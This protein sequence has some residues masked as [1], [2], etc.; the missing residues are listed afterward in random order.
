MDRHTFRLGVYGGSFNP[1]HI[2]HLRLVLEAQE[3]LGL[4]RVDLVPSARPPHKSEKGILPFAVRREL[5]HLAVADL[6]GVFVND[7][8]E[9]R[10]GP[11]YTID[12]L[13]QYQRENPGKQIYYLMGTWDLLSLPTWHRGLEL[14]TVANLVVIERGNKGRADVEAFLDTHRQQFALLEQKNDDCWSLSP[15]RTLHYVRM[16]RL[17]ISATL[18][19]ERF[20]SGKSITFFVPEAVEHGLERM[21]GMISE[22]W[23]VP[24]RHEE[25]DTCLSI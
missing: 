10:P 25:N 5:V 13:A 15:D 18:V 23:N 17:D 12:T 20:L 1:I 14:W 4:H 11:S 8:E 6:P 22:I 16:P 9:S 21:R 24:T 19:R 7:I 2:A 3:A